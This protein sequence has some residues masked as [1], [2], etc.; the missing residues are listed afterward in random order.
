MIQAQE[1]PIIAHKSRPSISQSPARRI[2]SSLSSV[3]LQNT[4]LAMTTVTGIHPLTLNSSIPDTKNNGVELSDT[5]EVRETNAQIIEKNEKDDR[6]IGKTISEIETDSD[7]VTLEN[8]LQQSP[9]SDNEPS[10]IDSTHF[11][12]NVPDYP[13]E[14]VGRL[15]NQLETNNFCQIA[16]VQVTKQRSFVYAQYFL[17]RFIKMK[18]IK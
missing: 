8:L 7:F 11:V 2:R 16:L 15:L 13:E 9:L 4:P 17:K 10:K 5:T 3:P 12:E 14:L 18:K 1:P 6:E